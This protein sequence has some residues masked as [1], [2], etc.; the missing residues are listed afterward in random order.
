MVSLQVCVRMKQYKDELL[1]SC[2]TFVLSLHYNMVALDLKAYCPALEV[3]SLHLFCCL[4]VTCKRM[5]T[6]SLTHKHGMQD[7]GLQGFIAVIHNFWGIHGNI[8][9]QLL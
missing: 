4:F 7:V 8:V 1:A 5:D 9:P 2:L 3:G 6:S